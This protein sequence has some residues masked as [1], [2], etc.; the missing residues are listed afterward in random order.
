VR[1]AEER[2]LPCNRDQRT[3]RPCLELALQV[4]AE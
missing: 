1:D 2:R 3:A 4:A